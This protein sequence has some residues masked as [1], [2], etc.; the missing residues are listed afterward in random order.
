LSFIVL[1]VAVFVAVIFDFLTFAVLLKVFAAG[2]GLFRSG[3][4]VESLVTQVLVIF[5][6][7]TTGTPWAHRPHPALVVGALLVI[8]LALGLPFTGW[9][10]FE[11][12]P[13]AFYGY[14]ALTTLLYLIL[15]Q[16]VKVY[17]FRRHSL[18]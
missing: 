4:F 2:P 8:L 6:I 18:S 12:L 16:A 11:P 5:V 17:F 7:R 1:F 9:L 13:V 3:W 14:I 10:G 15:V